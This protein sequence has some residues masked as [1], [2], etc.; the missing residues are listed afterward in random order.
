MISYTLQRTSHS[1]LCTLGLMRD[2]R[3]S[4]L[5]HTLEP[6][7]K[8]NQHDI[9]CI[10]PGTYEAVRYLS[11]K[12]GYELFRL[13]NVHGRDFIEIHIGNFPRDTEG[14]ILLGTTVSGLAA[15]AGSRAAFDLFM[16]RLEGVSKFTL[17]VAEVAQWQG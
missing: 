9:S 7:W 11:P 12:R 15:I 2:E 4:I 14:C 3:S 8:N 1:D 10:P 5:V 17:T 13:I 16:K 6:P